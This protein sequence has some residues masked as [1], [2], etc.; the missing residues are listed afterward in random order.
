M[1]LPYTI[2][3][4]IVGLLAT[5]Y[6]LADLTQYMYDHNLIEHH[7]TIGQSNITGH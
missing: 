4:S 7:T 5:Y 3:L 1:A 6:G 2:V